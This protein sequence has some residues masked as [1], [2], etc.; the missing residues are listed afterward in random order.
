MRN[1][2]R[3]NEFYGHQA[4]RKTVAYQTRNDFYLVINA[5][6][7]SPSC[8]VWKNVIKR[9]FCPY[10]L[11]GPKLRFDRIKLR[12]RKTLPGQENKHFTTRAKTPTDPKDKTIHYAG[13]N[14]PRPKR[15]NTSLR[16]R[17]RHPAKK[18]SSI[19]E[20]NPLRP[21]TKL[22]YA[23]ENS[24]RPHTRKIHASRRGGE[25]FPTST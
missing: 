14:S 20:R 18:Y 22:R 19:R 17:K 5:L 4:H 2:S 10:S 9:I 21:E 11:T 15:L 8:P 12:G 13:E 3:W 24:S 23:G 16:G 6:L 1:G 25:I 7:S